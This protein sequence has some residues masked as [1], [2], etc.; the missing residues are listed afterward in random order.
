M[1][2]ADANARQVE[3]L[4]P[5][6]LVKRIMW[7]A[8]TRVTSS[9]GNT[10]PDVTR[11]IKQQMQQGA[12]MMN[13][14]GHGRA[15]AISHEYVL[16]LND[17]EAPYSLRLPLWV[18]ASCDIMPFD[19]Q[20]EN[21]GEAAFF[22][23][24]G[25]A[26]AFYGT[27]RTV[28]QSYNR[29]MN[30]AFTRFVLSQ[31]KTGKPMP[32]GEAVRLTKNNTLHEKDQEFDGV[33]TAVMRDVKEKVVCKLNDPSDEGADE[34][35]VYYDRLNTVYNGSD[36]VKNGR[37]KFT[38]AVPKDINYSDLQA[39]MNLY[40]VNTDKTVMANGICDN[41]VLNGSEDQGQSTVGP[42][43]YCYLNSS[44]FSNGGSVN[45]TP[46]FIA[47]ISDEDGI[48]ASG[49]GIGH[50][51]QLVIDGE[52][53]K[54]YSLNDYFQFD[55][56]SYQK[57]RVGFSIPALDY[58]QHKLRFTAWDVLNNPTI[59][60]LA[61]KVEKSLEPLFLDVD[62]YPNPARTQTT[63]R[64]V[65]DRVNSQMDVMLDVYDTSGRHL[66]T[67][68]ENG[69]STN[70]TFTVNWDLTVDGGRRLH[71]G[72][73]LYKVSISSEGST[74]ASKTNKLIIFTHQ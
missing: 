30:M 72:L 56:G 20:E 1:A 10:Y 26:I 23:D 61:F 33:L 3:T 35:F 48:N 42:N 53:S 4:F 11:L 16:R 74:Y 18:T 17:F 59:A 65:H 57:G 25:G 64:I 60:E 66:W 47:E 63:F 9:T 37:F 36:Y 52:L 24:K 58:G 15:D 19:G 68:S 39:L 73:Y 43:I 62:C 46:Y 69:V 29:L 28:Y 38:F 54:T 2:D 71:T 14:S 55:F 34:P 67:H 41:L 12:L 50:D 40:A 49:S 6:L 5:N 27:T 44:A 31:D 13:Y 8:Y 7:D 70:N 22:N 32:I 21:I 45:S 51:L